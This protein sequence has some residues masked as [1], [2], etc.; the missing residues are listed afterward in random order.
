MLRG[1]CVGAAAMASKVASSPG[2]K[3]GGDLFD[4]FFE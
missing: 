4:L 1:C 2:R 3:K